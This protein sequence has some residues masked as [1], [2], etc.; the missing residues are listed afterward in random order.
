MKTDLSECSKI[1]DELFKLS[2]NLVSNG[3]ISL[4]G[5]ILTARQTIRFL[6]TRVTDLEK[7]EKCESSPT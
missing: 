7:D 6:A 3:Q 2:E 4:S 1:C 5:A